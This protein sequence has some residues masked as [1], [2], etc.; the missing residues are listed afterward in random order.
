ML[1]QD[2]CVS[3]LFD[4]SPVSVTINKHER[5]GSPY[6]LDGKVHVFNQR[7]KHIEGS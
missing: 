7:S 4:P 1:I 6:P 3:A 2:E 5:I